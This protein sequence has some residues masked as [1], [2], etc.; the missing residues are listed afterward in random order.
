[1]SRDFFHYSGANCPHHGVG[2]ACF[3]CV[4]KER[5]SLVEKAETRESEFAEVIHEHTRN[6]VAVAEALGIPCLAGVDVDHN[7]SEVIR[8]F[9]E[10]RA[11][12]DENAVLR[13]TMQ[14]AAELES[15]RAEAA[16]AE[17]TTLREQVS[18]L[19]H[20]GRVLLSK[21]IR[22]VRQGPGLD[23]EWHDLFAL[24]SDATPAPTSEPAKREGGAINS[25]GVVY[26]PQD[27]KPIQPPCSNCG[28]PGGSLAEWA[29]HD[30][31]AKFKGN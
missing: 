10:V 22:S 2:K 6:W 14:T 25:H 27:A 29:A 31:R 23:A 17:V 26:C 15:K 4:E 9:R 12:R 28:W 8:V 7:S 1:M 5:V 13:A 21:Y 20:T 19:K 3:D 18:A 24:C 11:E 16:L 30:C